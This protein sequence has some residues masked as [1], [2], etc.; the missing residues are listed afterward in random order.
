M[1]KYKG[2]SFKEI[3]TEEK[4]INRWFVVAVFISGGFVGALLA[5]GYMLIALV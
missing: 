5:V 1:G 4:T 3:M 2:M